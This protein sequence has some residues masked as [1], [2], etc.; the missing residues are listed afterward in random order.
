MSLKKDI[1]IR[2]EFSNKFYGKTFSA[3]GKRFKGSRGGSFQSYII[4]YMARDEASD[5]LY[6]LQEMSSPLSYL[7]DIEKFP[8]VNASNK[9]ITL[10]QLNDRLVGTLARVNVETDVFSVF[11]T[12]TDQSPRM[13]KYDGLAFN[14]D[15]I[16]MSYRHVLQTSKEIQEAFEAGHSVQKII[17]SFTD[18]YLK[19]IGAMSPDFIYKED[20]DHFGSI[21]QVKLR[22][23]IQTG[24]NEMLQ[25]GGFV[26]P[27][28][29]GLIQ[30]DTAHV[31]A[32]IVSVDRSF[33]NSRLMDD[34][35]DRGKLNK[36]EKRA[37]REACHHRLSL[38]KEMHPFTLQPTLTNNLAARSVENVAL[39]KRNY[40]IS[41]TFFPVTNQRFK[42]W[43][44]QMKQPLMSSDLMYAFSQSIVP[45][46][47]KET[48]FAKT[49]QE[50]DQVSRM[51]YEY[52]NP[53]DTKNEGVFSSLAYKQ[54][55]DE[56]AEQTQD[57]FENNTPVQ[58]LL[59]YQEK[60]KRVEDYTHLSNVL[61]NKLLTTK[62]MPTESREVLIQSIEYLVNK[63]NDYRD[64]SI[65]R[66]MFEYKK[67]MFLTSWKDLNKEL[68][69]SDV[70]FKEGVQAG[71]FS[72]DYI[73]AY[74]QG[75]KPFIETD[76]E[77][78]HRQHQSIEE[79]TVELSREILQ[80]LAGQ[81]NQ[82]QQFI[83]FSEMYTL[84]EY[85][86]KEQEGLKTNQPYTVT[87]TTVNALNEV[88]LS[89][90]WEQLLDKTYHAIYPEQ[91]LA[92][93]N[94]ETIV[95]ETETA[96]DKEVVPSASIDFVPLSSVAIHDDS[97]EIK[98]TSLEEIVYEEFAVVSDADGVLDAENEE[99][100]VDE[101]P[102]LIDEVVD[103]DIIE[104]EEIEEVI[105]PDYD[106]DLAL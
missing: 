44:E 10:A 23:A 11:R 90:N 5:A 99:T 19:E 89:L 84:E 86:K 65:D 72:S 103:D 70:L 39:L 74:L 76:I 24:M 13:L 67:E 12:V 29:I 81:K 38:L 95:L 31:H 97:P 93:A 71:Y 105:V 27:M 91:E 94:K 16:S 77:P 102:M 34:G 101:E 59:A 3:K 9:D 64:S 46:E 79:E 60:Q 36:N 18:D 106:D 6:P 35:L 73:R 92:V 88:M 25:Q 78:K 22:A 7:N 28:W 4:G 2:N 33:S 85:L 8:E 100:I 1:V 15:S 42:E 96:P 56:M 69:V 14:N 48:A 63:A 82:L 61:V 87:E 83:L 75:E 51:Y 98:S 30:L 41:P 37:F 53:A 52:K 58:K 55:I 43:Q 21:D 68:Y 40:C 62:E 45:D 104:E 54:L 50:F 17:V 49:L 26:D 47:F 80:N 66:A 57:L 32:H 20:G